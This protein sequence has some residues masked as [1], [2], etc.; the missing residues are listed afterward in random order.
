MEK[1]NKL[2]IPS[3]LEMQSAN[4]QT[5][6]SQADYIGFVV[7]ELDISDEFFAALASLIWPIFADEDG[8][9]L[10]KSIGAL[11][12][13][14]SFRANGMESYI[15]QYWANLFPVTSL[16]EGIGWDTAQ[17][18]ARILQATWTQALPADL[19]VVASVRLLEDPEAREL[20]V[21]VTVLPP[22]EPK[23][24]SCQFTRRRA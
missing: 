7:R 8:V 21:T 19:G 18:F 9:L 6:F 1:R 20:F 2:Q 11:D 4:A 5:A 15:A 14:L 12:R 23:D 22:G 13:Y 3:L 24:G 10:V 17:Q 16:F